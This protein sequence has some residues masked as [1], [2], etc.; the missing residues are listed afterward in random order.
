[1]SKSQLIKM[2]L[3][4]VLPPVMVIA[5]F[6]IAIGA[7]ILPATEEALMQKKKDMIQAIVMSATSIMERHVQ[8][9]TDGLVTA[10]EA[11]QAALT[12]MRALRYGSD[13]RDYLWITDLKPTMVMHP[14]F[15][16][17]EGTPL[18]EYADSNGKLFFV[19]AAQLAGSSGEGYVSYM[20]PRND[21]INEAVPKLSYIRLFQPWGLVVGSGIYLDD[22]HTEIRSVTI[23]LM[24]ISS[25]IGA[26]VLLIMLF[27]IYRGWKNE[28]GRRL[29][30]RE[31][32]LSHERYQ[33]LASASGEMLLLTI[34]GYIT[35]ANK[36]ACEMLGLSED[37]IISRKFSDF[38]DDPKVYDILSTVNTVGHTAS[39]DA[40][41]KGSDGPKRVLLSAEYA[42][43]HGSPA[44]MLAGYSMKPEPIAGGIVQTSLDKSGFG[45]LMI[46]SSSNGRIIQADSNA[47][48]LLAGTGINSIIGNDLKELLE[49]GDARRLFI[50]LQSENRVDGMIL[51]TASLETEK[52]LRVWASVPGSSNEG[53]DEIKNT[54]ALILLDITKEHSFVRASRDLT[55]EL[56]LSES[57]S[58]AGRESIDGF[59]RSMLALQQSVKTGIDAEMITSAVCASIEGVFSSAVKKAFITI[60]PPPCPYSLLAFGSIGRGEP[61]FNADQDTALIY[62]STSGDSNAG[63]FKQFGEIVTSYCSNAGIPPCNAGNTAA[64]PQWVMDEMEWRQK[65]YGWIHT[66]QPE[67]LILLNIFFDFRCISGDDSLASDL[68]NYIFSEVGK[69][70][71]FLYNLAQDTL[72]YR[73]PSDMLGRIRADNRMENFVNLKGTMLHYANFARIYSLYSSVHETNTIKRIQALAKS[74]IIPSDTAQDTIDAWKFL[75][76]LRLKM[77]VSALEMNFPQENIVILDELSSWD[78]S[79][80]KRAMTQV[81]SLQKR[82]T[83]DI[84]RTG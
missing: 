34:D 9:E 78:E 11:Q 15:P 81:N 45:T 38:I 27:I 22:V 26:V 63:Y 44:I 40:I 32:L 30:E 42:I 3:N 67:D 24:V 1:M 57:F 35:G 54:V 58:A 21:N 46:S 77:Q 25:W 16:E 39:A 51:R 47:S 72:S 17:L 53:P 52:H 2:I 18:D 19:E 84:V 61:T 56:L 43:V 49:A 64:N 79:M 83:A 68:H 76:K 10:E 5:L 65:F 41:L 36:R 23:R 80:L 28:K 71:L 48:D 59:T 69:R 31:L 29:A 55:G 60:G 8:M 50:Q 73:P 70:P 14:Y 37:N 6:A 62:R 66:S 4:V 82:L 20:W 75:M 12:E 7:V 13:S 33:A 74:G